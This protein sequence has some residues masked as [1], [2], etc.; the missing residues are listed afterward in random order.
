MQ[1]HLN[2]SL[3]TSESGTCPL[4]L[5]LALI[6]C[7]LSAALARPLFLAIEELTPDDWHLANCNTTYDEKIFECSDAAGGPGGN[8]GRTD[9]LYGE[10]GY[11]GERDQGGICAA[12]HPL[13]TR[14]D[15]EPRGETTGHRHRRGGHDAVP[16][17]DTGARQGGGRL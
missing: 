2:S 4:A 13:D 16:E 5:T 7:V 9:V 6:L 1:V 12:C 10:S 17:G 15:I 8:G 3:I 11:G 14:R